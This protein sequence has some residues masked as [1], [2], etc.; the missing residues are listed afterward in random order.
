MGKRVV[1][2]LP[3]T[4]KNRDEKETNNPSRRGTAGEPNGKKIF[5]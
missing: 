3:E 1:I 2:S 5:G 4:E